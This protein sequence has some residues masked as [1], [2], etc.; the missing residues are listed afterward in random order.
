MAIYF[1]IGAGFSIATLTWFGKFGKTE[2]LASLVFLPVLVVGFW[3]S[4]FV[5]RH[6]DSR[7]VRYTILWLCAAASLL[8]VVKSVLAM[9]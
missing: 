2:I 5:V 1:V 9:I 3:V 6:L 4:N 7:R 8:Q